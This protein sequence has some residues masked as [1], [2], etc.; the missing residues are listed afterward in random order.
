MRPYMTT[1]KRE[2]QMKNLSNVISFITETIESKWAGVYREGTRMNS[3]KFFDKYKTWCT[4]NNLKSYSNKK[5]YADLR[6]ID[7]EAPKVLTLLGE[8][9]RCFEIDDALVLE[10]LRRHLKNP[11]LTFDMPAE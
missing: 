3:D 4:A 10:T 1:Y 8:K 11:A 5:F 6:V 9:Q 2:Q 7:I